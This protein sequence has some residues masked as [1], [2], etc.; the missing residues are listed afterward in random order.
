LIIIDYYNFLVAVRY[1]FL[2]ILKIAKFNKNNQ[3]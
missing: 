1:N 3:F 2:V